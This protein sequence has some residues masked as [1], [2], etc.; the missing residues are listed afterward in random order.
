MYYI[1]TLSFLPSNHFPNV[2]FHIFLCR[3]FVVIG[4]GNGGMFKFGLFFVN[5]SNLASAKLHQF[6]LPE[7]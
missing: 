5:L 1:D 6:I 3:T 2:L 7:S 4:C